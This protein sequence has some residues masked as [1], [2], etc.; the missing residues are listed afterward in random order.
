MPSLGRRP[1][2]PPRTSRPGEPAGPKITTTSVPVLAHVVPLAPGFPLP[3]GPPPPPRSP[4]KPGEYRPLQNALEKMQSEM[5]GPRPPCRPGTLV[6][7][8]RVFLGD[9]GPLFPFFRSPVP[10]HMS[11]RRPWGGGEGIPSGTPPLIRTRKVHHRPVSAPLFGMKISGLS[12]KKRIS[13]GTYINR[14]DSYLCFPP[15]PPQMGGPVVFPILVH[16]PPRGIARLRR[17]L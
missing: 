15:P 6:L 2:R 17:G 16:N 3:A 8:L 11:N 12:L 1:D 5:V 7:N 14:P 13:S 10:P 4:G 9:G